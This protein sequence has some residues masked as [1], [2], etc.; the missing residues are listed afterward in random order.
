[1]PLKV[2]LEERRF[3]CPFTQRPY[4]DTRMLNCAHLK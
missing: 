1:L 3:Q 4:S 2:V